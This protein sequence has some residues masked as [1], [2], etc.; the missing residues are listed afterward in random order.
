[1][2]T[3]IRNINNLLVSNELRD[4]IHWMKIRGKRVAKT[5]DQNVWITLDR[6]RE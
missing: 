2:L 6:L 3:H 4:E 5:E 1:M